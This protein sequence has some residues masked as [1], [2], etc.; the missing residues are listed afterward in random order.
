MLETEWYFEEE[1]TAQ[2]EGLQTLQFACVWF[3]V[4]LAQN[5]GVFGT[6][7]IGSAGPIEGIR[8]DV[9]RLREHPDL[10]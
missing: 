3:V 6:R 5:V 10:L 4:I 7:R 2:G 8:F 1:H 9:S